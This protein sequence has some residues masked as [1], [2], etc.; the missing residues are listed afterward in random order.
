MSAEIANSPGII[1][2]PNIILNMQSANSTM[3]KS[4]GLAR[5][6]PCLIG[7]IAFYLQIHIL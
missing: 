5:N 7:N 1:Y 6:V 3:D 4:L 2:D